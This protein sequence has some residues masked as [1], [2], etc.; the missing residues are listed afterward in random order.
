MTAMIQ[1]LSPAWH[2][3]S[4]RKSRACQWYLH[5]LLGSTFGITTLASSQHSA[6]EGA[7]VVWKKQPCYVSLQEGS[8]ILIFLSNIRVSDL[9]LT[10]GMKRKWKCDKT[11]WGPCSHW[12]LTWGEARR[13]QEQPSGEAALVRNWGLPPTTIEEL[14]PQ[15][16]TTRLSWKEEFPAPHKPSNDPTSVCTL[17]ETSWETLS[18]SHPPKLLPDPWSFE[19]MW[20]IQYLLF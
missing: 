7:V 16:T 5:R 15:S 3:H 6:L 4:K 8:L 10:C 18:Q 17:T 14:R 19:T 12:P 20:D 2:T 9:F 13:H 11:L 1:S